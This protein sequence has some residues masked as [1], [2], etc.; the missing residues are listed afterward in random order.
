VLGAIAADDRGW[1]LREPCTITL[2][3][4]YELNQEKHVFN[5]NDGRRLEVIPTIVKG[6]TLSGL[7]APPREKHLVVNKLFLIT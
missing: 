6:L 1:G 3:P 5:E 7:V 2:L 4:F